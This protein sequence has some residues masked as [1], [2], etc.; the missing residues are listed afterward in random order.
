MGTRFLLVLTKMFW[1]EFWWSLYKHTKNHWI[2]CF[3]WEN[4]IVCELYF[5]TA[6]KN[7]IKS[8]NVINCINSQ[9][10]SIVWSFWLISKR[11][12]LYIFFL[13]NGHTHSIWKFPG[14]GLNPSH[15]WGNTKSFNPLHQA[16][17]RTHTSA[18]TWAPAVRFLTYCTTAETP[19]F[20][21]SFI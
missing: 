20:H 19:T 4:C 15:S 14:Q 5:N 2:A 21:I 17:G 6:I 11:L 10:R 3:H 1:D 13:I 16:G 8:I 7:F 12:T 18:A 9:G